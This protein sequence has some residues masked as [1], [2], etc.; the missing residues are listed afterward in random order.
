MISCQDCSGINQFGNEI[1]RIAWPQSRYDVGYGIT[2][3]V[4][5]KLGRD[6]I[7]ELGKAAC[8]VNL[9]E[10]ILIEPKYFTFDLVYGFKIVF[11]QVCFYC[12]W[13]TAYEHIE[14]QVTH[15]FPVCPVTCRFLLAEQKLQHGDSHIIPYSPE[16]FFKIHGVHIYTLLFARYQYVLDILLDGNQGAGFYVI[17]AVVFDKAFDGL[18]CQGEKL[19]LSEDNDRVPFFKSYI[20]Q[21]LQLQEEEIQ[22][23]Y[24]IE[25]VA[26]FLG[27][28]GKI[29][30]YIAFVSLFGKFLYYGGLSHTSLAFHQ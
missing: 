16:K 28:G 17:I 8:G 22:I 6:G 5:V 1:Q 9:V 29:N 25:Q 23:G 27:T 11:L 12:L 10:I 26:Y 14:P 13:H 7:E 15:D 30:Q 3:S 4:P 2:G 19:Y 21:Q 24:V 18:T 20:G